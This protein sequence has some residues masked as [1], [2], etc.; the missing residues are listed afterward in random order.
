MDESKKTV[1]S[2]RFRAEVNKSAEDVAKARAVC[3]ALR[4]C[5]SSDFDVLCD[6][7]CDYLNR[8]T[9]RLDWIQ[10]RL[11]GSEEYGS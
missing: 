4:G 2:A 6:V 3:A 7:A 5:H 10:D 8:I 11:E 9:D 1:I